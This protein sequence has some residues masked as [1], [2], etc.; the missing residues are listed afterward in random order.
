MNA[1]YQQNFRQRT[2]RAP[3]DTWEIVTVGLEDFL[4]DAER[5]LTH[6]A[7]NVLVFGYSAHHCYRPSLQRL[8]EDAV[9]QARVEAIYIL[10]ATAE[11]GWTKVYYMPLDCRSPEDF[12]NI[13]FTGNWQSET[14][15]HEPFKPLEHSAVSRAWCAFRRLTPPH[16]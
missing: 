5:Y 2:G 11:H 1:V 10:D 8:I 6:E 12:R 16:R 15:W 9:L 4:A 13:A 14:L 7:A 3:L